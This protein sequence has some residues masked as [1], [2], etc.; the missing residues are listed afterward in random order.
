VPW[1]DWRERKRKR[2]G[3]DGKGKREERLFPAFS[4]FP[5]SPAYF[6]SGSLCAEERGGELRGIIDVLE[7]IPDFP[8]QRV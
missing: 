5:S 8:F 4:L 1:G 3:L 7:V 2:A 6:P